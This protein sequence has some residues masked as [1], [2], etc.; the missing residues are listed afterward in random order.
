MGIASGDLR[1]RG[2]IYAT[3][4]SQNASGEP[5]DNWS[6]FATV[7][8]AIDPLGSFESERVT[9]T[10]GQTSHRIR[11]R[12][13]S[14]VTP[15]MRFVT[16]GTMGSDGTLSATTARLFEIEGVVNVEERSRET[17]LFCKEHV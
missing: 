16:K 1:N 8:C 10:W 14:G 13:T 15:K 11:M 3:S 7:R 5:I 12:Y 4:Q 9:Q 17:H 6:G 2:I